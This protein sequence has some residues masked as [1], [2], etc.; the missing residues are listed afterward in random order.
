LPGKNLVNWRRPWGRRDL[1]LRTRRL[2]HHRHQRQDRLSPIIYFSGAK[3]FVI[4]KIIIDRSTSGQIASSEQFCVE[5]ISSSTIRKS[6]IGRIQSDLHPVSPNETW[7]VSSFAT[8]HHPRPK[9]I[10]DGRRA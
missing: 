4:D 1:D 7:A 8:Q 6:L 5:R 10:Y 3:L 2:F 9:S